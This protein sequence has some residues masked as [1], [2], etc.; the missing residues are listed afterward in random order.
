[1]NKKKCNYVVVVNKERYQVVCTEIEVIYS[2]RATGYEIFE[3]ILIQRK[4]R[5]SLRLKKARDIE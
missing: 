4:R 5:I 3:N 1:M 2:W